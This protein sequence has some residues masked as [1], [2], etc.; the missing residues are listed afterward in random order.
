[1]TEEEAERQFAA[2]LERRGLSH[3]P[4]CGTK[5]DR[6]HVAWNNASTEAGTECCSVEIECLKCGHEIGHWESWWPGIDGFE[7]LVKNVLDDW[8]EPE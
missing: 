7:D 5:I 4:E 6:G 1:M 8:P 2:E 3:C